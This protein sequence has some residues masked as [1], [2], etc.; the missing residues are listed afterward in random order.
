MLAD[1]AN[2]AG[3]MDPIAGASVLGQGAGAVG[4]V[5]SLWVLLVGHRTWS[6]VDTVIEVVENK[7]VQAIEVIGDDIIHSI[8]IVMGLLITLCCVLVRMC[9]VKHWSS[10]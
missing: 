7:T 2:G 9:V 1:Q 10:S 5:A 6:A 3:A 4:F 8:P